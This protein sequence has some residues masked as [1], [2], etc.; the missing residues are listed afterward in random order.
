MTCG[1]APAPEWLETDWLLSQFAPQRG[2]AVLAYRAFVAAG[3]GHDSPLADTRH[4][5]V[6][7]DAD[8]VTQLNAC[9]VLVD[10]TE[11]SRPQKQGVALTLREYRDSV[12]DRHEAMARAYLGGAYTMAEVAAHFAVH[13]RTVS[14]AVRNF[15]QTKCDMAPARCCR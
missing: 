2:A 11:T 1:D 10:K 9:A 14:R 3:H 13:Y 6:L 5:L 7:G 4:Q 12:V 8:F 15:E